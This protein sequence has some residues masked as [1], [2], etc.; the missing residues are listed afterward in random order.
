MVFCFAPLWWGNMVLKNV[1]LIKAIF[2]KWLGKLIKGIF[3]TSL[4]FGDKSEF[5]DFPPTKSSNS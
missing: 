1:D 2:S 4:S 5:S 3:F